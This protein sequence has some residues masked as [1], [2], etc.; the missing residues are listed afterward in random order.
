MLMY[1]PH[2]VLAP[3]LS[4]RTLRTRFPKNS[5]KRERESERETERERE[6][7]R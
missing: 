7:E 3:A 5:I 2:P 1:A 4:Q 6:R